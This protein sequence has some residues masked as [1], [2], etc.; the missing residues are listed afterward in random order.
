MF[1]VHGLSIEDVY[2]DYRLNPYD[3][4]ASPRLILVARKTGSIADS[5]WSP[6]VRRGT[7]EGEP[8]S[9]PYAS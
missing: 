1:A 7:V 8:Q 9:L 2:G 3:A 6:G 5:A 4:I